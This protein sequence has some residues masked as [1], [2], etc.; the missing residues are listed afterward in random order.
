MYW[1][2]NAFKWRLKRHVISRIW[3]KS[4]QTAQDLTCHTI[5]MHQNS[6]KWILQTEIYSIEL[7]FYHVWYCY[8]PDSDEVKTK[9]QKF[10]KT[11]WEEMLHS[12]FGD[13]VVHTCVCMLACI[14][15]TSLF[16]PVRFLIHSTSHPHKHPAA[17][18]SWFV[19]ERCLFKQSPHRR[20]VS[21]CVTMEDS[22]PSQRASNFYT[23][24]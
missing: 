24:P 1:T 22:H 13:Q 4:Q 20:P 5:L 3:N 7:I 10:A 12:I 6:E 23:L 21:S 11:Y 16:K 9:N 19:Y 18:P 14:S 8:T 17:A 2:Q 15:T